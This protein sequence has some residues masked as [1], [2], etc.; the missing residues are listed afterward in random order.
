M[1]LIWSLVAHLWRD[2]H[3]IS[4]YNMLGR[5]A[6]DKYSSLLGPF[7][8]YKKI[9]CNEDGSIFFIWRKS[10]FFDKVFWARNII[11]F[12]DW[13]DLRPFGDFDNPTEQLFSRRHGI[14][15]LT[16]GRMTIEQGHFKKLSKVFCVAFSDY[17]KCDRSQQTL[18]TFRLGIIWYLFQ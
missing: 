12:F 9:K 2:Y 17:A 3:I 4:Q 18:L 1:L 15:G 13:I 7:R 11:N 5:L 8:N 6:R 16:S 10:D 14:G